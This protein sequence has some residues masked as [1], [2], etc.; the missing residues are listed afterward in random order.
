[1]GDHKSKK[2]Q[3]EACLGYGHRAAH[4]HTQPPQSC[5]LLPLFVD[6][7]NASIRRGEWR[8]KRKENPVV[9]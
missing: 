2:G 6:A 7:V 8:P 3:E 5:I 1:M 9:L 4:Q